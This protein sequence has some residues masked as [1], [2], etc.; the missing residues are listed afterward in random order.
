MFNPFYIFNLYLI[1]TFIS[2][3][4]LALKL[5]SLYVSQDLDLNYEDLMK[6]SE[7]LNPSEPQG[8]GN[9]GNSG[10]PGPGGPNPGGPSSET[11]G[12]GAQVSR[13]DDDPN[14]YPDPRSVTTS[15][16]SDQVADDLVR[17]RD[18]LLAS[19]ASSGDQNKSVY[20][21]DLKIKI[22]KGGNYPKFRHIYQDTF[23]KLNIK[24]K[25]NTRVTDKWIKKIRDLRS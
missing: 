7:L 5:L 12:A 9:P 17:K 21:S 25:G 15:L 24:P 19:R 1:Y 8:S 6:I 4:Y 10:N 13:E 16:T 20:L 18:K 11:I 14:E 2:C 23:D 22:R 3:L